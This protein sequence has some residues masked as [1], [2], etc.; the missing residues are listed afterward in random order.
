MHS[1]FARSVVAAGL[2]FALAACGASE[3]E[4][5]APAPA[6]EA[7][8]SADE[9]S[10]SA[11]P[12]ATGSARTS[13]APSAKGSGAQATADLEQRHPNGSVLRVLRVTSAGTST[14]VE[15]EAV[16]G[17][18]KEISLNAKGIHLVDDRGNGYNFV[19]PEQN[20]RLDVPPAGTLTGTLTFLGAL[21]R[22]A[23][24]LRLLINT[25]D[26]DDTVDLESEFDK[27]TSP[28][29][30]IDGLPVPGRG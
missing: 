4:V 12:S 8:S 30:Q 16:N 3:D 25:F 6:A 22:E 15:V 5:A 28:A 20:S 1:M 2:V 9:T 13:S 14:T 29:F 23:T 24:S 19:E 10:G 11:S 26:A 7:S 17:Y 21:D 27:A 18:T